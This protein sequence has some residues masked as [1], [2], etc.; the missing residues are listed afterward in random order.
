MT[1]WPSAVTWQWFA[2]SAT[3]NHAGGGLGG[4][5]KAGGEGGEGG[6]GGTS[7]GDGGDGGCIGRGGGACGGFDP[8]STRTCAMAACSLR[9]PPQAYSNRKCSELRMTLTAFHTPPP[10]SAL[11]LH[12]TAPT[13]STRRSDAP[14][15]ARGT[16][17]RWCTGHSTSAQGLGRAHAAIR[18][19]GVQRRRPRHGQGRLTSM[20]R[21]CERGDDHACGDAVVAAIVEGV[22][23]AGPPTSQRPCI[24]ACIT[25][26]KVVVALPARTA[27][28]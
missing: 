22:E 1:H 18:E 8:Q 21:E 15:A 17:T 14:S 10:E 7:G 28:R 4:E 12:T 6:D 19:Q 25:A 13:S 5:G 11:K 3:V 24:R 2:P 9:L 27:R 16:H 23:I 20:V 26:C